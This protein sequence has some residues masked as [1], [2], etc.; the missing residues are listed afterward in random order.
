MAPPGKPPC[1]PA[2]LVIPLFLPAPL[3]G[4]LAPLEGSQEGSQP[5]PGESAPLG[6]PGPPHAS[7]APLEGS[8]QLPRD[9]PGWFIYL[10]DPQHTFVIRPGATGTFGKI[11]V[12]DRVRLDWTGRTRTYHKMASLQG[13]FSMWLLYKVASLQGANF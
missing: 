3:L 9:D 12:Q 13:G 1:Q 11:P 8:R 10:E 7:V 4:E 2:H 5:N 6:D